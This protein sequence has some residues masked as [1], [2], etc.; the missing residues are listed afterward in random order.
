MS[1]V[2]YWEIEADNR[3]ENELKIGVC[4]GNIDKVSLNSAF[5]DQSTGF[6]YYGLAQLRN[7]SNATGQVY[8]RRF[9]KEGTLGVC[10]NMQLG[11]L[12]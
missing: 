12:L 4:C 8:G 5:C 1:G 11:S 9:K 7:G 3:T 2:H 6:A 10:L